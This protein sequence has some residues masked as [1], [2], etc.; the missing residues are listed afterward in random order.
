M[1]ENQEKLKVVRPIELKIFN[2][3]FKKLL[4]GSSSKELEKS[5]SVKS[6]NESN[7]LNQELINM[8]KRIKRNF[9]KIF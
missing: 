9:K 4:N 1:S 6:K 8:I 2:R 3:A 7:T 5:E